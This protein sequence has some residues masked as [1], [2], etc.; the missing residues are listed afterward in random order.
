MRFVP[1]TPE[2]LDHTLAKF[3]LEAGA[4][5]YFTTPYYDVGVFILNHF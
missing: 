4:R 2:N 1:R 3:H 5:T